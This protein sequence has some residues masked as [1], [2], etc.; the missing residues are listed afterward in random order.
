MK[1]ETVLKILGQ[2]RFYFIEYYTLAVGW[3][4]TSKVGN[5]G[6]ISDEIFGQSYYVY[7]TDSI[8]GN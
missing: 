3:S 5:L 4:I 6:V 1:M 7:F 8:E 2:G